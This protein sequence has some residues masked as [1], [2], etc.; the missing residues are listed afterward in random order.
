LKEVHTIL[1]DMLKEIDG[2]CRKYGIVY[3]VAGG[4]TIGAVRHRGFIP[5]DDDADIYMTRDEFAK[6]RAAFKKE[7]PVGRELG[8]LEDNPDYPGTIPRYINTETTNIARFNLLNTCAAGFVIDIFILDPVPSDPELQRKHRNYL[9][10]YADFVMPYYGFSYRNDDD[11]MDLYEEYLDKASRVG[12]EAVIKELESLLF[13]FPEEECEYYILRWGTLSHIFARDMMGEPEY[14]PYEGF[15]LPLPHRWYD[16]LVQL[17]GPEWIYI[18]PF[19]A[20][21]AHIFVTNTRMSYKN[22]MNDAARFIDTAKLGGY[23]EARKINLVKMTKL[24]KAYNEKELEKYA[25]YVIYSLRRREE[26]SEKTL[27]ELFAARDFETVMEIFSEYIEIQFSKD[28]M[29]KMQHAFM[30]RYNNR[31]LIKLSQDEY[32]YLIYAIAAMGK[33]KQAMTLMELV[34]NN[35]IDSEELETLNRRMGIMSDIMEH[36]YCGDSK[37]ARELLDSL[38][39]EYVEEILAMKRIEL[40]VEVSENEKD[41]ESLLKDIND[42]LARFDND[43]EIRKVLADLY[44]ASGNKEEAEAIY[45]EVLKTCRNGMLLQEITDKTGLEAEPE[46]VEEKAAEEGGPSMP[47]TDVGRRHLE[48]L[49]EFDEI[50]RE[51]NINYSLSDNTLLYGKLYGCFYKENENPVVAMTSRNAEKFIHVM[52]AADLRDRRIDYPGNNNEHREH[53]IF[54]EDT[55]TSYVNQIADTQDHM[56]INIRVL[57][58]MNMSRTSRYT[59]RLLERS[60]YIIDNAYKKNQIKDRLLYGISDII[61]KCNGGNEFKKDLFWRLIAEGRT[62]VSQY[63]ITKNDETQHARYYLPV[64]IFDSYD[65]IK[66]YGRDFSVVKKTDQYIK[67]RFGKYGDRDVALRPDEHSIN[68]IVNANIPLDELCSAIDFKLHDDKAWDD[69]VESYIY[70]ERSREGTQ[71]NQECWHI[72]E[73]SDS[74]IKL[75]MEYLPQKDSII[76]L[77]EEEKFAELEKLLVDYDM[78]ARQCI[79][80]GLGLCFDRD[81][82]EAYMKLLGHHGET[83]LMDKMREAV[84][85]IHYDEIIAIK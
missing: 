21:E 64:K 63:Y 1:L 4:T 12:R 61:K 70:A 45:L 17:Y 11:Y 55:S 36:F 59:T 78:D 22:Y 72:M 33:L 29:G 56:R 9:N 76:R 79:K 8:C 43:I 74:R 26:E 42:G 27:E 69:Y 62:G 83:E 35:G 19:I 24:R 30:Y 60:N 75:W 10:V 71:F 80:H 85:A 49:T 38:P 5:W 82:F 44:Y 48:L 41:R 50:C 52:E 13:T 18:P 67:A 7:D 73:R 2:I 28:Y 34:E 46:T 68:R 37:K 58:R 3:Y 77:A 65:T 6:F 39:D 40:S 16:Y 66:V 57:K 25:E 15:D 14:F 20:D 23:L 31:K 54:Y 51:N 84:P 81:I 32:F 53:T 47:L